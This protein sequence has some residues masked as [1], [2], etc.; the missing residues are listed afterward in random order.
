MAAELEKLA[1]EL[2][3]QGH[4]VGAQIVKDSSKSW[5]KAGL[6]PKNLENRALA[7]EE[8]P[9]GPELDL[10]AEWQHQSSRFIAFGYHV[11]LGLTDEAYLESL[12]RFG[13][14]PGEY[15]GRLDVPLLVETRI[16][17]LRQAE[18][19]R[20]TVSDYLR[21]RVDQ[22]RPWKGNNFQMPEVAY[23]G[24]FNN[25]SQRFTEK[26]APYEAR[27]QLVADEVGAGPFEGIAL[28]VANPELTKKGHYF[29]LI[30]Y[31]VKSG[32]VPRLDHWDGSPEL[33][34]HWGSHAHDS[35]RPLV[36]GSK[37]VIG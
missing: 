17:W 21:S 36:R 5:L 9:V 27:K 8:K 30:G 12:P 24:Y 2:A 34:A 3:A 29:D 15:R 28:Q 25:W 4:Q 14:Q 18:L 16:S 19:A 33:N 32:Y 26:I 7:Q 6:I 20:I 23:T 1:R 11:E 13:P 22:T 35:F 10:E 37:L 31:S